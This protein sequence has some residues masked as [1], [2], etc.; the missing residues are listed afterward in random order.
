MEKKIGCVLN[1]AK[2][3]CTSEILTNSMASNNNSLPK[4]IGRN[5]Y[6]R[7]TVLFPVILTIK[8]VKTDTKKKQAKKR[9]LFDQQRVRNF[10]KFVKKMAI[11]QKQTDLQGAIQFLVFVLI[12]NVKLSILWG[13]RLE[14]AITN[15]FKFPLLTPAYYT[16][17]VVKSVSHKRLRQFRWICP[18]KK[19]AYF[20]WLRTIHQLPFLLFM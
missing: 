11:T 17:W 20:K 19:L 4:G 16:Y 12:I 2:A 13:I 1:L 15:I 10:F 18:P 7:K 9:N 3:N 8:I 5:K 14:S 6:F